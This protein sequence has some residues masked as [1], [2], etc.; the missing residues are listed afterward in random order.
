MNAPRFGQFNGTIKDLIV[1]IGSKPALFTRINIG[2]SAAPELVTHRVLLDNPTN[3]RIGLDEIRSAFPTKL[4]TLNDTELLTTLMSKTSE[5]EGSAVTVAVE[6]QMKNGVQ[7]RGEQGQPYFNVRLRS[8]ARDLP[9]ESAQAIATRLLSA[10]QHK[11][12]VENA[13]A[14]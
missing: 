4:G 5:F 9:A 7:V 2:T 3:T 13:F 10:V 6:A 8:G 14:D 11:N 1:N 12:D